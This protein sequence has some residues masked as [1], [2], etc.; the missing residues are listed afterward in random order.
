MLLPTML[1]LAPMMVLFVGSAM[2]HVMGGVF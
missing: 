1:L 2:L